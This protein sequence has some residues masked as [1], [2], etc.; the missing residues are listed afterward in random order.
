[1]PAL[2]DE[3]VEHLLLHRWPGNIRQLYNEVRRIAATIEPNVPITPD[4]LAPEIVAE[5]RAAIASASATAVAPNQL[6]INLDQPLSAGIEQLERAMIQHALAA[7]DGHLET[8]AR[9]LAVSRKGL[10]LKRQRLEIA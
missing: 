4:V 1:V 2:S 9:R 5:R 3:A 6:V 10:F 8:A 7:S